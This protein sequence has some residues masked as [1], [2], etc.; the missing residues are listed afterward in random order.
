MIVIQNWCTKTMGDEYTPPELRTVALVGNVYGHPAGRHYDGKR[1]LTSDI[2]GAIGRIVTTNSGNTYKL[3][4]I[5]PEFRVWLRKN[6]PA[7]DWRNPIT[8]IKGSP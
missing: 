7:W 4:K 2:T 8:M 5:D 6:R 1:V 3:G